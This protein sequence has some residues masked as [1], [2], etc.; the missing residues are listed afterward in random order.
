MQRTLLCGALILGSCVATPDSRP[1]EEQ[2]LTSRQAAKV[3]TPISSGSAF[4]ISDIAW[5]TAWHVV[6]G[7]NAEFVSVAGFGVL[8]IVRLDGLDAAVL[9]TAPH[10]REPWPLADRAPRPGERVYKSGFGQG[11][12]WWT[13]GLG[14]E[15]PE[16]VAIDIFPGDSGCPLFAADGSVVGIVVAV[17]QSRRG[18][19]HHHCWIVPMS[20]VLDALPP[21]ILEDGAEAPAPPPA[22]LTPSE[23][24]WERFQRRKKEL[25]V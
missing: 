16:R 14:S 7:W 13:E 11:L 18:L 8:E 4:P 15:D 9:I 20:A 5:L 12:H 25:G 1:L 3:E 2:L 22:A 10:G 21:G 24:A 17:G 6:E 19:I 23:E